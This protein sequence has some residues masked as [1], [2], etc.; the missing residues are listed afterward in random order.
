MILL[1]AVRSPPARG[2]TPCAAALVG[3]ISRR[4]RAY[5]R[6]SVRLVTGW[7]FETRWGARRPPSPSPHECLATSLSDH[8]F[9]G[10]VGAA[11]GGRALVGRRRRFGRIHDGRGPR[12]CSPR[13]PRFPRSSRERKLHRMWFVTS[14]SSPPS[15]SSASER[16][17]V[18]DRDPPRRDSAA[19]SAPMKREADSLVARPRS[20][21]E[22]PSMPPVAG[23]AFERR[24]LARQSSLAKGTGFK[25]QPVGGLIGLGIS[26]PRACVA[27]RMP[28]SGTR[29]ATCAC[30]GVGG[31][32]NTP[33]PARSRGCA[34]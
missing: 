14:R 20:S 10:S 16:R 13:S 23:P 5:L 7:G 22:P 34:R 28:K 9:S 32:E 3:R 25:V 11:A 24:A 12:R 31:Y 2:W 29:R 1:R 26:P 4:W 30:M 18:S 33:A 19:L 15:C 6:R 8:G 27:A 21:V 17:P